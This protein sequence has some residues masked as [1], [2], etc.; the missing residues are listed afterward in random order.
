MSLNLGDFFLLQLGNS[1]IQTV[2]ES[3]LPASSGPHASINGGREI[4]FIFKPVYFRVLYKYH[5]PAI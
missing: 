5:V 2:L 4:N 3:L 1:S